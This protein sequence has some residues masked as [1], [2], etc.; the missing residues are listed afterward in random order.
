MNW[1]RPTM[2]NEGGPVKTDPG[3]TWQ[4]PEI[5]L[6]HHSEC[7]RRWRR[8]ASPPP[9]G[10]VRRAVP[11]HCLIVAYKRSNPTAAKPPFSSPFFATSSST[12]QR[13]S[14]PLRPII[15]RFLRPRA[16]PRSSGAFASGFKARARFLHPPLVSSILL[17]S[18][19]R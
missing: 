19:H 12:F 3:P 7:A 5:E 15:C 11:Q 13:H 4:R 2:Y 1:A 9:T 6:L 10:S 14:P 17:A 16:A 8:T 18:R